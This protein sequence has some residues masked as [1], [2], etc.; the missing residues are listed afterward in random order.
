MSIDLGDPF[1]PAEIAAFPII[2]TSGTANGRQEKKDGDDTIN[3]KYEGQFKF[4]GQD[5]ICRQSHFGSDKKP[6]EK[7]Y[8]PGVSID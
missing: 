4:K 6:S 8:P 7:N 1:S 3:D 2:I 5:Q